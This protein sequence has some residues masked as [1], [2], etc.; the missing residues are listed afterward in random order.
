MDSVCAFGKKTQPKQH[1]SVA[2]SG[3]HEPYKRLNFWQ[4][5]R[6]QFACIVNH[7]SSKR[8][9]IKTPKHGKIM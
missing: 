5:K 9:K 7:D 2:Q 4:N 3:K 1:T 8:K 6:E